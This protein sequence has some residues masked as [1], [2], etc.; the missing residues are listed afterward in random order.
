MSTS[1]VNFYEALIFFSSFFLGIE[2]VGEVFS[3]KTNRPHSSIS[4]REREAMEES[5]TWV[6][7]DV[8]R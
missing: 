3:G 2:L 8:R 4:L 1:V 5:G 6:K 7:K